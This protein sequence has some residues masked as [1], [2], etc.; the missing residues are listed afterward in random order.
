MA[1]TTPLQPVSRDERVD[2]VDVV[3]GFA[4]YGVL[5]ANL[6]WITTDVVLTD[7]RQAQLLTAPVDRLVKPLIAFFVDHKFYTLFSFL[8]GQ[9]FSIQLM[10]A[11]ARGRNI[12]AT[13]ARRV[14][15]FGTQI[16]FSRWWLTRYRFGT[17]EWVWRTLTYGELQ[18]MMTA[19][20][21]DP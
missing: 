4:L 5:L 20:E 15:I 12:V 6:V 19:K 14:L 21:V 13:Y 1:S 7:A 9:G 8:F 3:R 10:R 18:P 11:E 17:A 2:L 16:V